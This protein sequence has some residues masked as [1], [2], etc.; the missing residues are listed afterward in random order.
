MHVQLKQ[1]KYSVYAM[2]SSMYIVYLEC[3]QTS[4]KLVNVTES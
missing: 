1:W 2:N 4:T 3:I